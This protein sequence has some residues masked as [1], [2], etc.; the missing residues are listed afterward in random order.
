[1]GLDIY[2]SIECRW[3]YPYG[4]RARSGPRPWQAAIDLNLLD[5]NRNYDEWDCLFG[6][7]HAG[8]EPLSERRGLPNDVSTTVREMY[9][10]H[11]YP[12]CETWIS[13]TEIDAADWDDVAECIDDHLHKYRR[14]ADGGLTFEDRVPWPDSIAEA[15]GVNGVDLRYATYDV[16]LRWLGE[17][18]TVDDAVLRV[19]PFRRRD[20]VSSDSAWQRVWQVMRTLASTEYRTSDD[21][22]LIVWFEP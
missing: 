9:D 8:F 2:G 1:M 18:F 13:L 7:G 16:S 10:R 4:W 14:N 22:R 6:M 3:R 20:V 19:E 21:V 15:T 5:I 17:E 12:C 11:Q